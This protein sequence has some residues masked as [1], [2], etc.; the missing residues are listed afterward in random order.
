[1]A[2]PAS[3]AA[4]DPALITIVTLPTWRCHWCRT[5]C[6]ARVRLDFLR[7]S[8]PVRHTRRQLDPGRGHSP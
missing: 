5:P 7:H 4:G 3:A 1:M 8:R 2:T 6:A